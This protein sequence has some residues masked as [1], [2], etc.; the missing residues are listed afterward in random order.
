MGTTT[1]RRRL[2]RGGAAV[3]VTTALALGLGAGP[4]NAAPKGGNNACTAATNSFNANMAEAKFWIGA[5]DKLAAAGNDASANAATD[6]AN[7]YLDAA[8]SALDA[9]A[10]AC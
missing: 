3:V 7:H 10:A 1:V 5:A 2:V 9:M 6:E 8:D 4:A